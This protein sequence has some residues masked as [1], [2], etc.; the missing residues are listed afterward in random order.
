[1]EK[2]TT[3]KPANPAGGV[4]AKQSRK[5]KPR[6]FFLMAPSLIGNAAGFELENLE[7]LGVGKY[8]IGNGRPGRTGFPAYLE[9]PRFLLD[10]KYGRPPR[11]IELYHQYWFVS[12]RA[13]TLFETVDPKG[14][15]FHR[16]D[17][18]L[19]NG[20]AGPVHWLCDI[21]RI[22]DALDEEASNARINMNTHQ[23]KQYGIGGGAKLVFSEDIVGS[24]HIFRMEHLDAQ[25]ICD[26]AMRD[27]CKSAGLKGIGF[28]DALDTTRTR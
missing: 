8:T 18:R 17:I 1:M 16:C 14:F 9:T 15:M 11:D 4:S 22:L 21:L 27:A 26:D 19:R 2:T 20:E 28:R 23:G 7:R 5:P 10:K 24:A 12:D 25:I 6:A 13:K 3:P